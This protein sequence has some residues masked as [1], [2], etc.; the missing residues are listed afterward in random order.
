MHEGEQVALDVEVQVLVY[1]PRREANPRVVLA[2]AVLGLEDAIGE[3]HVVA[4][5]TP[6]QRG[7]RLGGADLPERARDLAADLD[8][9]RGVG[10]V[11]A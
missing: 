8:R 9:D 11:V 2:D 5:A 1:E 4:V 10:E 3:A 7:H 6:E